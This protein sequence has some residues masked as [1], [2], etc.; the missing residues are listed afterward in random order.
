VNEKTHNFWVFKK[1]I[2]RL[3][4]VCEEYGINLEAESEAWTSQTCP[5]CGDREKT[6]RHEDTLTCPCGFEEHTDLTASET[7]LQENSNCEVRPMARPVQF[8]VGR[9]RLVGEPILSRNS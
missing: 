9:P 5:E 1:F 6:V 2:H 3:A 8:G 4:C 7:F